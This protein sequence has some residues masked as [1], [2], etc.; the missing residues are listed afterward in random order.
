MAEPD[1]ATVL[2]EA[3]RPFVLGRLTERNLGDLEGMTLALDEGERW[4]TETLDELLAQPFEQQSRGPLEVFQEAMIFPT[5]ILQTH[6]LPP[7][8]RDVV[9]TRALPGDLYD[10]APASSRD[11][12]EQAW[13]AHLAWGV[14]KAAALRQR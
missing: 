7:A 1:L 3:F 5:R 4:L 8:P 6:G 13:T 9:A 11:L 10:L 12:G 14:I 2:V